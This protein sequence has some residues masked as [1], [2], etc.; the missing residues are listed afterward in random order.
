MSV[1]RVRVMCLVCPKVM[2]LTPKEAKARKFCSVPC[3][4]SFKRA[5]PTHF[6]NRYKRKT[7]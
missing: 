3:S 1:S 4:D 5:N 7:V 2:E 6:N